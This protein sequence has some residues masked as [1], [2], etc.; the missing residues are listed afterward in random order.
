MY[1]KHPDKLAKWARAGGLAKLFSTQLGSL[2]G[3]ANET[4]K[5]AEIGLAGTGPSHFCCAITISVLCRMD[6]E[7]ARNLCR[8]QC[9][10]RSN[11]QGPVKSWYR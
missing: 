4:L 9:L 11:L 6:V 5:D 10:F 7:K 8:A 2:K 3:N 1:F